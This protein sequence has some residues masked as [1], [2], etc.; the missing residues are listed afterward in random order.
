MISDTNKRKNKGI[1]QSDSGHACH[2][3]NWCMH[4]K[5][6][7]FVSYSF[8]TEI[9]IAKKYTVVHTHTHIFFVVVVSECKAL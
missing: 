1:Y 9:R 4:I 6:I 5:Q 8:V 7:H 3:E 2:Q